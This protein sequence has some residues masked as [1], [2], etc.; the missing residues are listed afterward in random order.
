VAEG[1]ETQEQLEF[2]RQQKCDFGQGWLFYRALS[3]SAFEKLLP[4]GT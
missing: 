3:P 1:I 4:P 2:L